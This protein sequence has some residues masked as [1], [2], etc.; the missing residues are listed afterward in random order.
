MIP[1]QLLHRL[2]VNLTDSAQAI[3]LEE[4]A[5]TSD[6]AHREALENFAGRHDLDLEDTA[7]LFRVAAGEAIGPDERP[8]PNLGQWTG[9]I[10]ETGGGDFVVRVDPD[11]T[12]YPPT[13]RTVV[14]TGI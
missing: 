1:A 11:T 10:S 4:G 13:G 12:H 7:T 3:D 2:L 5:D 6:A 9:H 8:T 14:V